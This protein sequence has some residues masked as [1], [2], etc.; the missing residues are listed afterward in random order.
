MQAQRLLFNAIAFGE[1]INPNEMSQ[2]LLQGFAGDVAAECNHMIVTILLEWCRLH[3]LLSQVPTVESPPLLFRTLELELLFEI[4]RSLMGVL[5]HKHS[6]AL[7]EHDKEKIQ[8]KIDTRTVDVQ[9]CVYVGYPVIP[10]SV[11]VWSVSASTK[12]SQSERV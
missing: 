10:R 9:V 7:T 8:R 11:F 6:S 2:F 5:I 4:A 3:S 12:F 1:L